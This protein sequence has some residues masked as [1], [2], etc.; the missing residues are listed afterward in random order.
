MTHVVTEPCI[1]CKH[2]ECV[3]VCPVDCF[4]QGRHFLVIDPLQCIDCG[5]CIPVCPVNA[6]YPSEQ[7]PSDQQDFIALNASLANDPEWG[8]ILFKQAPLQGHEQWKTVKDKRAWL[9]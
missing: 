7:I 8:T 5:V 3:E 1:L 9:N 2:T 6:I 4:K